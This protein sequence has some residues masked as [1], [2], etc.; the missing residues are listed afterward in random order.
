VRVSRHFQ[1]WLIAV[2]YWALR[3]F[4][5]N[6]ARSGVGKMFNERP[7]FIALRPIL[8][9]CL[10]ILAGCGASSNFSPGST[11]TP[12]KTP[13]SVPATPA[14]PAGLAATPGDAQVSLRWSA[15]S[16]ATSYHVKRAT[17]SGGPYTQV[18]APGSPPYTDTSVTDGTAYY[19]V[20]SAV[21]SASESANSAQVSALPAAPISNP[22]ST[23]FGTWI[24]VTPQSV[25]ASSFG[26]QT[27]GADPANPGTLYV[28]FDGIGIWKSVDY[29]QTWNGPVNTGTLG[30]IIGADG[31]SGITVGS[32]GIIYFSCIRGPKVGFFKSVDGGVNW[33]NYSTPLA[34][35]TI[36]SHGTEQDLYY[37]QID[38]Y[39]PN[40]LI[41]TAHEQPFLFE[42]LDGGQTWA[43]LP[44]AANMLTSNSATGT[45]FIYFVNTGVAGT[46]GNKSSGGTANTWLWIEQGTG[47]FVG[48][49]RTNNGGNTWTQVST[50]EHNHGTSS[51][52]QP[53]TTG[54]IFMSGVYAAQGW[55]VMHSSDYGVT[56][57]N[58]TA[59]QFG[60]GLSQNVIIG[61]NKNLYSNNGAA[62]AVGSNMISSP[63]P[64]T[65]STW[66]VQAV[67]PNSTWTFGTGQFAVVNDG[68]H[69]VLVGAMWNGGIWRY[70]EP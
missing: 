43:N 35:G 54:D 2:Y 36:G 8:A 16:G 68:T 3:E 66:N 32:N 42:S 13:T 29:G 67:A 7:K 28:A 59:A 46:A 14:V 19:Y 1:Y 22:P 62:L 34:S 45:A 39:N 21:D 70:V 63:L 33:V 58:V 5:R 23:A 55:G 15:S 49:W 65:G 47:G 61:T 25:A 26:T 20:V 31:G 30:S 44:L 48:T 69:N 41:M 50:N 17:A 24:N 60:G 40:H 53:N 18:A 11:S 9:G 56:W 27:I 12:S 10:V 51:I 38:P 52:Y 64:G 6:P 57:S 4:Q 37:P